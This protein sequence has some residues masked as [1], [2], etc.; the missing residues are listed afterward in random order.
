MKYLAIMSP[1]TGTPPL[2]EHRPKLRF[3][4]RK[5]VSS[6]RLPLFQRRMIVAS[7]AP[8]APYE[9]IHKS[10][11][12]QASSTIGET[13]SHRRSG[14]ST[15]RARKPSRTVPSNGSA[16]ESS[17]VSTPSKVW[18]QRVGRSWV[19]HS[20]NKQRWVLSAIALF[21]TLNLLLSILS[22]F[23]IET[24]IEEK[25]ASGTSLPPSAM[26]FP[27]LQLYANPWGANTAT[28]AVRRGAPSAEYPPVVFSWI[29]DESVE[30]SGDIALPPSRVPSGST[31]DY[32]G[33]DIDFGLVPGA[34]RVV[35]HSHQDVVM[36]EHRQYQLYDRTDPEKYHHRH[37]RDYF[38]RPPQPTAESV[39][40]PPDS[41][42]DSYYAF[43]DDALRSDATYHHDD[44]RHCRRT[45]A[46]KTN[47]PNCNEF[48]QAD[49]LDAVQ[50]NDMR[51]I[52]HGFFRDVF[53]YNH[54]HTETKEPIAIKDIVFADTDWS[55]IEYM[56]YVRVDAMVAEQLSASPHIYDVY[57]YCGLGILSEF[58]YHGDL[59]QRSM[60]GDEDGNMKKSEMHD[61]DDVQPQ[62]DLTPV[63]KL[64]IALEM[65]EGLAELHGNRNGV[66]I[67]DDVQLSQFLLNKDKS[68]L[69]L[70]DFNRVE[71]P[72]WSEDHQD[73]CMYTNGKG[74]GTWRSPEEYKDEPLTEKI[75][76]WSYGSNLYAVLTG[77]S[78]FYELDEDGE[79]RDPKERMV[80][81]ETAF[82]DP[83][84]AKRSEA[85][86]TIVKVL[87]RCFAYNPED[88]AS[89]FEIVDMLSGPTERI[90]S[91]LDTTRAEVLQSL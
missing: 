54:H 34:P 80:E 85:E 24:S 76:V 72:L 61:H 18:R 16:E 45:H 23:W 42:L 28:P 44:G 8:I 69:L 31:P 67:H 36:S 15:T 6:I 17:E 37:P 65:A 48:H 63:Q 26:F 79:Q 40:F 60:G 5:A 41:H 86:F 77:L 51:Y 21:L 68:R 22:L 59:E 56:E 90:L 30:S 7:L 78:P 83:R 73:Y 89:I 1:A 19:L 2:E 3:F 91:E 75:D 58:F 4:Q 14:S 53:S 74:H 35:R 39:R 32:G 50:N 46:R 55:L 84:Y 9:S 38:Y 62:N 88:R 13:S 66:I 49:R 43:D 81:G 29:G 82:I 25:M 27:G 10:D 52:N 57:G 12:Q 47:H 20:W 70:N 64:V 11:V 87:L 33:L 71:Y